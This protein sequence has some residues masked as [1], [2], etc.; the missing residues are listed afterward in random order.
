[1]LEWI[2]SFLLKDKRRSENSQSKKRTLMI[3]LVI[4]WYFS[5]FCRKLVFL[6]LTLRPSKLLK[7]AFRKTD[8]T[9]IIS[10]TQKTHSE[11]SRCDWGIRTHH[12]FKRQWVFWETDLKDH[13]NVIF[14]VSKSST[15]KC[16][17]ESTLDSFKDFFLHK[18]AYSN[19]YIQ[20]QI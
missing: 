19:I 13:Q 2:D 11:G 12:S 4:K 8:A 10:I 20:V 7:L 18:N 1:M 9:C 15:G 3:S 14:L 6:P 5:V 16:V 17:L